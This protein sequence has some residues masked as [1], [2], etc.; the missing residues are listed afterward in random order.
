MN[1]NGIEV[2][3]VDC[4]VGSECWGCCFI[5]FP[6]C[7]DMPCGNQI[8]VKV[9]RPKITPIDKHKWVNGGIAGIDIDGGEVRICIDYDVACVILNDA[10]LD[11]ILAAKGEKRVKYD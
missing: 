2:K 10:D 3:L 6:S 1:I 5:S 11:V 9:E 7:Q 4:E 8:F